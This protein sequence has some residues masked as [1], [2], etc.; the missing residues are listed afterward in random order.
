VF[1]EGSQNLGSTV[2]EFSAVIAA[3]TAYPMN[4]RNTVIRL[5]TDNTGVMHCINNGYSQSPKLRELLQ[6]LFSL[7]ADKGAAITAT[8]LPGVENV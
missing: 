6:E 7:L 4:F 1:Q 5:F 8:Y 2:R 3:I